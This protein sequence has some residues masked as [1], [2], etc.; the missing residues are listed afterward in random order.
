MKAKT[1]EKI[2]KGEMISCIKRDL[3]CYKAISSS[4]ELVMGIA[5]RDI[6]KGEVIEIPDTGA[7][8]DV[9]VSGVQVI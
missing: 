3:K 9:V 7:S 2:Y 5:I 8:K 1:G 6:A 4:T